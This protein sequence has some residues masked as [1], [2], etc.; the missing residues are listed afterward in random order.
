MLITPAQLRHQSFLCRQA[1][2]KEATPEI[3]RMLASHAFALA[4]LA[5]KIER[6][7]LATKSN[8]EHYRRMLGQAPDAARRI[9]IERLLQDGE[10]KL[11]RPDKG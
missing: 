10:T 2:E 11:A 3:K 8:I 7:E 4:Q 6:N 1:V 9:I 5:E